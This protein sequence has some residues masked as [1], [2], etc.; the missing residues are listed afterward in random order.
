MT[1]LINTPNDKVKLEDI[2]V[3]KEYPDVF[4]EKLESLPPERDIVFKI[5]V[6]PR[7]ASKEE[8]FSF[9]IYECVIVYIKCNCVR[10]YIYVYISLLE[11]RMSATF[12]LGK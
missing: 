12:E 5:D 11:E 4:S 2:P 9:Y 1:F 6:T 7:D 3:V 10:L 8:G